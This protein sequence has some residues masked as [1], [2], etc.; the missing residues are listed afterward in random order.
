[1]Q[2]NT[3]KQGAELETDRWNSLCIKNNLI[4]ILYHIIFHIMIYFVSLCSSITLLF[5]S[6]IYVKLL[7]KIFIS[8]ICLSIFSYF[9]TFP[10][11][12]LHN[13]IHV[14]IFQHFFFR[15]IWLKKA[16]NAS[17]CIFFLVPHKLLSCN[18]LK[19]LKGQAANSVVGKVCWI[20]F[21]PN[22]HTTKCSRAKD[23]CSKCPDKKRH[24]M[25]QI[26]TT[27]HKSHVT[28]QEKT[29]DEDPPACNPA[30]NSVKVSSSLSSSQTTAI[31]H[32]FIAFGNRTRWSKEIGQGD[33]GRSLRNQLHQKVSCRGT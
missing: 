32:L 28:K 4:Y 3:C 12:W 17:K 26:D 2:L 31:Q 10:L 23:I 33:S 6:N 11:G 18:K 8:K 20:C 13:G 9:C 7:C 15:I 27:S 19:D 22:H 14:P 24:F 29:F 25:I 1:M 30:T 16:D 21:E 5:F